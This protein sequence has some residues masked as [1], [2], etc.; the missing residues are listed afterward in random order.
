MS[1]GVLSSSSELLPESQAALRRYTERQHG[2]L[3][4]T[5]RLADNMYRAGWQAC[6]ESMRAFSPLTELIV[7]LHERIGEMHSMWQRMGLRDE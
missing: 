2:D 1:T 5:T 4:D 7:T 6:Y 3:S